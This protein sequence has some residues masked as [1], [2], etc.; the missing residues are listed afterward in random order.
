MDQNETNKIYL[1]ELF[2]RDGMQRKIKE[3]LY[4]KYQAFAQVRGEQ[5]HDLV[6]A[7]ARNVMSLVIHDSIE[8]LS[9]ER[10]KVLADHFDNAYSSGRNHGEEIGREKERRRLCGLFETFTTQLRGGKE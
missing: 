6:E 7:V 1:N 5:D 9:E 10:I 4:T 8:D 2:R 3:Y